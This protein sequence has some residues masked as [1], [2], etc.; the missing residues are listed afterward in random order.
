MWYTQLV[1]TL[2]AATLGFII[3]WYHNQAFSLSATK[4]EG[5]KIHC[6]YRTSTCLKFF[7]CGYAY[8]I[9]RW[10][11]Y[12]IIDIL[13]SHTLSQAHASFPCVS[14]KEHVPLNWCTHSCITC[15]TNLVMNNNLLFISFPSK[16][17]SHSFFPTTCYISSTTFCRFKRVQTRFSYIA[18]RWSKHLSYFLFLYLFCERNKLCF[19]VVH[20]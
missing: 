15:I 14:Q 12:T 11:A 19:Y 18:I 4:T 1:L 6:S 7:I 20:L 10:N 9:M 8:Y 2:N 17:F 13:N 16:C 5:K 3:L